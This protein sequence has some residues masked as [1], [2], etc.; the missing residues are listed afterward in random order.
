MHLWAY[1]EKTGLVMTWESEAMSTPA[2]EGKGKK[3]HPPKQKD[4]YWKE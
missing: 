4:R 2:M 1:W 3:D